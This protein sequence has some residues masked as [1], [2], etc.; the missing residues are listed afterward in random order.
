M[1]VYSNLL[2]NIIYKYIF[3]D[4]FVHSSKKPYYLIKLKTFDY[5]PIIGYE[6]SSELKLNS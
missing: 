1:K 4:N 2:Y 5:L 6:N 3:I